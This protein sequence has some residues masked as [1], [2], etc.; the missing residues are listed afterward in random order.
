MALRSTWKGFLKL[1][2]VSVPVRAFTANDTGSDVR[3]NQ[4][5]RKTNSRIQYKKVD[6]EMGEVAREDI[7]S[8]Y[9]YSKGQY[10]IIEPDEIEKLRTKND[11]A[12]QIEG[13]VPADSLDPIHYSGKDY[14]LLPDGAVGQKPYALLRQ[15]MQD[16]GVVALARVVIAKREQLV[17]VREYEGLLLMT[18]LHHYDKVKEPAEFQEELEEQTLTPEELGLTRTLIEA[19]R[20]KEFDFSNYKDQYVARLMSLIEKKVAGQEIVQASDPEEP[21]II[22]LMDALKKSVAEAQAL[23]AGG[24]SVS[25]QENTSP[26]RAGGKKKPIADGASGRAAKKTIRKKVARG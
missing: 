17:L 11:H 6:P 13:F 21:K 23:A 10:V 15:G 20:V 24:E 4:L 12:V 14:Y 8:A 16:A 22:N 5:N 2:L 18:V 3:L 26:M 19:S 25:L 9:E 1:S 7:V